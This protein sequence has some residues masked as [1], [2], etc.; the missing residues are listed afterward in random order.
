MT[1]PHQWP[2]GPCNEPDDDTEPD[3]WKV[4]LEPSDEPAD[5]DTS[6]GECPF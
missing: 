4:P 2:G 6:G 1:Y 5:Y 3:S